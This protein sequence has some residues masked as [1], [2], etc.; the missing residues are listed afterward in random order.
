MGTGHPLTEEQV[1]YIRKHYRDTTN[2][3]LAA[4]VGCS[5]STVCS[6]QRRYGL[7][8]SE[9]HTHLMAVSSGHASAEARGG[10]ALAE[11]TPEMIDRRTETYKKTFRE[12]RARIAFGLPRKTRIKASRQPKAKCDQRCYLKRLGY[13]LDEREQ[14][15]Y[16]TPQTKR[17]RDIE[18]R[19]KAYYKFK[20]Y[21]NECE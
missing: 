9:D 3:A 13:I 4:L 10:I 15:A 20:P 5:R 6:I 2:K 1:L 11:Y 16:W 18:S 17:S 12:E 7:S 14:V 21:E 19:K 8:K